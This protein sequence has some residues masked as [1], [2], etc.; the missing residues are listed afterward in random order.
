[1]YARWAECHLLIVG[2]IHLAVGNDSEA[3]Q[4]LAYIDIINTEENSP[5]NRL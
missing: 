5:D 4:A 1:M 3:D 2:G